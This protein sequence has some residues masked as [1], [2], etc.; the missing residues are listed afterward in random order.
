MIGGK[1]LKI[2][3]EAGAVL[4]AI[5]LYE[6]QLSSNTFQLLGMA[7]LGLLPKALSKRSKWFNTPWLSI[8]ISTLITLTISFLSFSD[9]VAASNFLY[10]LAMLIEFA[11]FI[12]LRVKLPE[13][14]RPYKVPMGIA[15]VIGMC[16]VPSVIL[17][18]LMV[19]SG[20]RVWLL[21]AG[22]MFMAVGLYFCMVFCRSKGCFKFSTDVSL[23]V[24]SVE[25]L[26]SQPC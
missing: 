19:V 9:I 4:S 26:K 22:L 12:R 5:G 7:E 18:F 14:K 16:T 13:L 25:G 2:W 24:N 20:W 11:A 6:A 8:L 21:S 23:E 15:G 1:W 10:S 3:T 17:I